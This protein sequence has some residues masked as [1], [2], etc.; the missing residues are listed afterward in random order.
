RRSRSACHTSRW[1]MSPRTT[2]WS[3]T[4]PA[5]TADSASALARSRHW[6]K[7]AWVSPYGRRLRQRPTGSAAIGRSRHSLEGGAVPSGE[8]RRLRVGALDEQPEGAI[9]IAVASDGI[10]RKNELAEI[11]IVPSCRRLHRGVLETGRF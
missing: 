6:S 9:G 2:A 11:G 7:A 4:H 5:G 10:V 8:R 3:A 1:P